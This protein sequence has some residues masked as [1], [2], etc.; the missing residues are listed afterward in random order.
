MFEPPRE[1]VIYESVH[2]RINHRVDSKLPGYLILAPKDSGANRFQELPS[3]ALIEMGLVLSKVT[4]A[5]EEELRPKH[6]YV[7]RY[8]HMSGHNFHFHIIP[9]YE[10]VIEAFLQDMQYRLLSQFYTLGAKN[11]GQTTGFDGAEMTL[12][13]WRELCESLTPPQI[14]GSTVEETIALLRQKLV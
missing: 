8:G 5:I 6:L 11:T 1:F 3:E 12:Y 2:W 7:S 14:Q 4:H 13:I 9:V 10:W